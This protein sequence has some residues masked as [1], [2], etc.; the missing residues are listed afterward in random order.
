MSSRYFSRETFKTGYYL[1][2]DLA[3]D[4]KEKNFCDKLKKKIPVDKHKQIRHLIKQTGAEVK[5]SIA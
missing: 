3:D 1:S 5:C 4:I 2:I